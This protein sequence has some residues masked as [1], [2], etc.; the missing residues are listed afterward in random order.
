ME[1]IL[2]V[3]EDIEHCAWLA[4]YLK[5]EG[6]EAMAVHEVDQGLQQALSGF[7]ALALLND[8][9][10][11]TGG[12]K[13]LREI[14][15]QSDMPVLMMTESG[16]AMDCVEALEMGADD[17]LPKPL[18]PRELVAR[19]R[20]IFRRMKRGYR[21]R[22]AIPIRD[23]VLVGDIEVHSSMRIAYLDGS[24]IEFTSVEF[25]LL[26]VLLRAT[27]QVVSREELAR[28]ALGRKLGIN[29]RSIDVH[30]SSLRKKLGQHP[31]GFE[32]IRTIR[33]LGYLYAR[34]HRP[35]GENVKVE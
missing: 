17:Y 7:Y 5:T 27:G 6:F 4:K 15:S 12:L 13:V 24:L 26:E 35:F 23:T 1:H 20:A 34:P 9:I 14:R 22:P 8:S 31:G 32:R 18:N 16:T 25:N 2:I 33:N 10:L 29:D 19:I 30:I 3:D 28:R 21:A 11:M